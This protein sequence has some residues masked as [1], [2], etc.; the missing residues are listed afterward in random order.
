MILSDAMVGREGKKKNE[1]EKE[2]KGAGKEEKTKKKEKVFIFHT[3]IKHNNKQHEKTLKAWKATRKANQLHR[4]SIVAVHYKPRSTKDTMFVCMPSLCRQP[5]TCEVCTKTTKPINAI[6]Q[7]NVGNMKFDYWMQYHDVNSNP[8]WQ[9]T[10]MKII[11]S[12]YL[13]G[14]RSDFVDG[15]HVV[16]RRLWLVSAVGYIV[17]FSR[18]FVRRCKIRK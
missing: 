7:D 8:R 3:N 18:N 14:K 1:E 5:R 4:S 9:T 13:R 15:R 11:M 12:A 17:R 6:I 16:K 2:A 10:A